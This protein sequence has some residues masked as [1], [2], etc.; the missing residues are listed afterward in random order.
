MTEFVKWRERCARN[1][2]NKDYESINMLNWDLN[3]LNNA[4]TNYLNRRDRAAYFERQA[5]I[6][7]I[8]ASIGNIYQNIKYHKECINAEK[9]ELKR[10]HDTYGY[11]YGYNSE[12]IVE[13]ACDYDSYNYP[14]TPE[15]EKLEE[16]SRFT[17]NQLTGQFH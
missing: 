10:I 7:E 12:N 11:G 3:F 15:E 5:Q 14:F 1:N 2:I 4:L 8:R 16:I 17:F 13:L 6:K 9:L